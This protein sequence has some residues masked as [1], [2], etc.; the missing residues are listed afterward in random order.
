MKRV[1][2]SIMLVVVVCFTASAQLKEKS[3][4]KKTKVETHHY[5]TKVKRTS[6]PKQ[7]IHNVLHRKKRH[8]YKGIKVRHKV[9]H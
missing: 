5:M 7:K 1:L 9:K 3:N 2:L 8:H 4:S 6:T